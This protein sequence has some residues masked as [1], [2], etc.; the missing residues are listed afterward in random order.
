MD[1]QRPYRPS[2][3][4]LAS[5]ALGAII[6]AGLAFANSAAG[7]FRAEFSGTPA[8]PQP[9]AASL[10]DFDVQVHDRGSFFAL[11]AMEAQHGPDCA[12]P[13]ATHRTSG[14]YAD[15]VFNCKD[16]LMTALSSSGYGVI[17]LTP[18]QIF[19]FS[20]GGSITFDLSTERMSVRDWWD[21]L[22]TPYED[23]LALPLLSNLSQGTDLQ[24]PPRNTIHVGTDN[25]EGAPVLSTVVD[26]K[27]WS[28]PSWVSPANA[29][30]ADT[31]NQAATRQTF[32][33]TIGNGRMKFERLASA[34]APAL[35]FWDVAA[36]V[37]FTSGIVQFGHHSYNPAKCDGCQA[38]TWHWDNITLSKSTPFTMIKADRRYTQG[39][40]VNFGSPAPANAYLRFAG[41]CEVSV[42]GQPVT[43]MP[44]YDRWGVGYKPEHMSS[45]FVPIAEGTQ[46]VN[47]TFDAD[48]WYSGPCIAKDFSIWSTGGSGP[49]PTPAKSTTVT[50][51]GTN[52]PA[53]SPT[54][55]PTS[56]NQVTLRGAVSLEGIGAA[57]GVQVSTSPGG[58]STVTLADGSFSLAGLAGN[59]SYTVTARSPGFLSAVRSALNVTS[60]T[61]T[62]PTVVL[63]AGDVDGDDAVTIT[64]VSVVA[65]AFGNSSTAAGGDLNGNGTVDIAD[66]S[67]VSTNFGLVGPTTW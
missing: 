39:G 67:I 12:G 42:D 58:H 57:A 40:A 59:Q 49:T 7:S 8:K 22:I 36:A 46:S 21:V 14:S 48:D 28:G 35:V 19:D 53:S 38:G 56:T 31:V 18:G 51:P 10:A 23:N 37:P 11:E 41:I 3:R 24:G 25:G 13:P 52:T 1:T 9:A 55:A 5:G 15:A 44:T 62:L 33:L 34:T 64:D 27:E 4:L 6:V 47:F 50:P 60:G 45:Y 26:G 20:G 54:V 43:R 16:H 63:R 30:I 29:G 66:V 32:K 17:Y 2:L 61:A 65:G